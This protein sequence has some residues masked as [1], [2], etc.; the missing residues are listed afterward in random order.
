VR[1]V[2][3]RLVD[4]S[5]SFHVTLE[6]AERLA[7]LEK[8]G[9]LVVTPVMH[10]MGSA[11][12]VESIAAG[13]QLVMSDRSPHTAMLRTSSLVSGIVTPHP[14]HLAEKLEI[15]L[16]KGQPPS[17]MS[18]QPD[19]IN[20]AWKFL[21]NSLVEGQ[22][23]TNSIS[24]I[25]ERAWQDASTKRLETR[26]QLRP[27][28]VSSDVEPAPEQ[29]PE[30][31]VCLIHFER[32]DFV[33]QTIESLELQ[34]YR[35]FEVILVDDGSKKPETLANL[36]ALQLRFESRGWQVVRQPNLSPGAARNRAASLARGQYL[37][38]MDDD[39]YAKPHEIETFLQ[40]ARHTGA[41]A[42]TC[43][44]DAFV[45]NDFPPLGQ[46]AKQRIPALGS[47]ISVSNFINCFGDT[48]ALIRKQAYLAVGGYNEQ[49]RTGKEDYEFFCKI[50]LNG[51]RLIT[52]PEA[53]YWYREHPV[54]RKRHHYDINAGTLTV[55]NAFSET[56]PNT[57]RDSMLFARALSETIRQKKLTPNKNMLRLRLIIRRPVWSLGRIA[58]RA[59]RLVMPER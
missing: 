41:D 10:Q 26:N 46:L 47:S 45:G 3:K 58:S 11:E 23:S 44:R 51:F 15:A 18:W 30:V 7:I 29:L 20:T 52:I 21:E 14:Y 13:I 24:I 39:N 54:K 17:R 25:E 35:N 48:N 38:F 55:M 50:A 5:H 2:R 53:L 22:S 33:N 49:H 4:F 9:V 32:P 37:L 59:L 6:K 27:G 8:P 56:I 34:S 1:N 42:I 19:E 57:L 40:V 28:M 36:D 31:S 12:I 43:F 16:T